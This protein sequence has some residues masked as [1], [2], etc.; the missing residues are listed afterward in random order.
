MLF[1][2]FY[3]LV[4]TIHADVVLLTSLVAIFANMFRQESRLKAIRT[5]LDRL[6]S[7]LSIPI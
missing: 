3:E 6:T 7:R 1:R 2:V 4:M 5:L